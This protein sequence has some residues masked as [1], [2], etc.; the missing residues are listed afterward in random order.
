RQK[1]KSDDPNAPYEVIAE[2]DDLSGHLVRMRL[3]AHGVNRAGVAYRGQN[4]NSNSPPGG[5]LA[6]LLAAQQ[7]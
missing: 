5:L 3:F 7:R 4:Q 1:E 6:L 2:G